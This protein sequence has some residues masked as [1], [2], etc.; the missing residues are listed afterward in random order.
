M[1][2]MD[3]LG[4][5]TGPHTIQYLIEYLILDIIQVFCNNLNFIAKLIFFL[6]LLPS[7]LQ[8]TF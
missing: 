1:L 5:S 4:V 8:S 2:L 3:F 6:L 7:L